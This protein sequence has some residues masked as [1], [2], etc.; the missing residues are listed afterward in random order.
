MR[1]QL[2]LNTVSDPV[3][4]KLF[5]FRSGLQSELD[6]I[7]GFWAESTIDQQYGGFL[8]RISYDGKVDPFAEKSLILNSRVLWAFSKAYNAGGGSMYLGLAQRSFEFLHQFFL[9]K[10]NGGLYWS[11]N[12]DGAVKQTRKQVYGQA[13]GI[14]GLAEYY[15]ASGDPRSLTLAKDLFW[16]LEQHGHDKQFG[17][18]LEAF[19]REWRM[20]SDMRLSEKEVNVPKTMNT[21]LHLLEAFANLNEVWDSD[22]LQERLVELLELFPK[23]IIDPANSHQHL[24][25]SHDWN[26]VPSDISYGH[27]IEASW[28]LLDAAE[29]IGDPVLVEK[30]RKLSVKITQATTMAMSPEGG[31]LYESDWTYSNWNAER[32]W[33]PQVEAMVGYFNAWSLTG[34]QGYLDRVFQLWNFVSNYLMDNDKLDWL[35]GVDASLRPLVNQ[36]RLGFWKCPYH[37]T[38]AC[39][40]LI[41]RIGSHLEVR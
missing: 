19:D 27:D 38:R 36:D 1:E 10:Q 3:A 16:L 21:H 9:D 28:L 34:E 17:G 30:F 15:K 35:W 14:Y 12:F 33:W 41:R 22:L 37:H 8:G 7:L 24:F 20:P 6:R 32:H 13:F 29:A 11:V 2:I 5:R 31:L 39:H 23:Y 4:S 18:Y 40:E 26:R 25:F